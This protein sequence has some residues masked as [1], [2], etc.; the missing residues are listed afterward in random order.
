M[1]EFITRLY[2]HPGLA[3]HRAEAAVKAL[4]GASGNRILA[5]G[6]ELCFYIL[7]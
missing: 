7:V 6:T 4:Q 1:A 2:L 5:A 3:P